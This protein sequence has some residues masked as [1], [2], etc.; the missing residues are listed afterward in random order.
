MEALITEEEDVS[1][2]KDHVE[3]AAIQVVL[4]ILL[5]WKELDKMHLH[6]F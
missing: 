2:D 4:F 1:K 5:N 3:V 6:V